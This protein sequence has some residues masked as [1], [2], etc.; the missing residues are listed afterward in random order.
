MLRI[1]NRSPKSGNAT[2]SV[3]V[4]MTEEER[5]A[6]LERVT[7]GETPLNSREATVEALG[8]APGD[9]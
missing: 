5:D 6:L 1:G 8:I 3:E 2:V 4:V 9:G 7:S